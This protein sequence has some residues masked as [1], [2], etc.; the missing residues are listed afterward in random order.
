MA[1]PRTISIDDLAASPW[2]NGKGETIEIVREPVSGTFRWRLSIATIAEAADFSPLPG[3]A[4]ML[5]ALTPGP[6]TLVVDGEPVRLAQY[7]TVA[8]T[9]DQSVAAADPGTPQR[10]L[11]LMVRGGVPSLEAVV[12]AGRVE[13][14]T[15]VVAA[16]ALEGELTCLGR[17]LRPGDTV[18]TAG[19]PTAIRGTG[20]VAFAAVR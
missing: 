18:V 17:S 20:R 6:L 19:E 3:V 4:R 15:E 10:D 8:F 16:V 12:V 7:D 5:M 14:G 9:G 11:N 2:A 1:I 13:A